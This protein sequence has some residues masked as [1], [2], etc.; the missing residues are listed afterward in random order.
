MPVTVSRRA[1]MAATS[2]LLTLP[3]LTRAKAAK[4]TLRVGLLTDMSGPSAGITGLGSAVAVKLAVQ[5][6]QASHP[7]FDAD[8][9]VVVADF[10][11]KSDIA[12]SIAHSWIEQKSVDVIV[13]LP[14]SAA[15][16][17]TITL[18]QQFDKV[19]LLTESGASV[20]TGSSCGPNHIQWTY[21]T[22]SVCKPTV[23]VLVPAGGDSWFFLTSDF[24]LGHQLADD[25]TKFIEK[26]GGKVL[27]QALFP[28]SNSDFSSHLLM[29]QTSKAKVIGLAAPGDASSH[30]ASSRPRNSASCVGARSWLCS[31]P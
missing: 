10:Q 22:Y 4:P 6:F 17:G 9:D 8:I 12:L 30:S 15:A 11:S 26:D 16:L 25:S 14:L 19:G 24:T 1:I 20:L 29:A 27:G 23:D 5:D 3:P 13:G 21:D 7:G 28:Y 31:L 2:A 18:L